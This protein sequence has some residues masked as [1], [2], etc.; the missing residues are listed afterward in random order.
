MKKIGLFFIGLVVWVV[1]FVVLSLIW[2]LS[3]DGLSLVSTILVSLFLMITAANGWNVILTNRSGESGGKYLG[4][5]SRI[6][7]MCIRALTIV[8]FPWVIYKTGEGILRMIALRKLF[9][10]TE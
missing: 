2:G 5:I 9:V 10:L 7:N 1:S 6:L 3:I 4:Y 8:L